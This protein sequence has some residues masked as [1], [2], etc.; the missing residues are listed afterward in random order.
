MG[1]VRKARPPGLKDPIQINY[2]DWGRQYDCGKKLPGMFLGEW[3]HFT[4]YAEV[5]HKLKRVETKVAGAQRVNAP[6]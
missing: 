6:V 1:A 2:R 5:E 3:V 4:L